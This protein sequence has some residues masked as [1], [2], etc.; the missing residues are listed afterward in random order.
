MFVI[1]SRVT[2]LPPD[3][4]LAWERKRHMRILSNRGLTARA[5]AARLGIDEA[6]LSNVIAG[7]SRSERVEKRLAK[8]WGVPVKDVF[9]DGD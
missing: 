4:A 3:E 7:R 8:L 9:P 1:V 5:I 2:G 6:H